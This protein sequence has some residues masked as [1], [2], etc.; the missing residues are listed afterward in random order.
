MTRFRRCFALVCLILCLCALPA[1]A[2]PW[3]YPP[4][5]R[6]QEARDALRDQAADTLVPPP[7]SLFAEEPS[8]AA[9]YAAGTLD[10]GLIEA[11]LSRVNFIRALAGLNPVQ[12]DDGLNDI[13]Q[14]GAVLMA[15]LETITHT[16]EKP[17]DMDEAFFDKGA[18]AAANGNLAFFN[19]LTPSLAWESIDLFAL[20]DTAF[21]LAYLGHRRWLL[22][23]NMG[24]AG[25]G[26]ASDK[27]GC[28]YAVLYVTDTSAPA[29]YDLI[30]WPSEGA[31]P[32]EL[33]R[34]ETPWSISLNTAKYD[35]DKSEPRVTLEER[36]S[37][38]LWTFDA[39][40]SEPKGGAYF[41]IETSGYG[42]GPALIFRPDL[43]DAPALED[44][45]EQN[46][47]W[48]VTLSGLA[49]GDGAPAEDVAYMVDMVSLT[50]ID[51]ASVEIEP[52]TLE[53]TVGERLTVSA[54][55]YPLWAD[56]LSYTLSTS[57]EAVAVVE[58]G[59]IVAKAEGE[60]VLRAETVNGR[61]D[62]VPV[63]VQK[64]E[65]QIQR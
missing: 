34:A 40:D 43:A 56:D 59:S 12:A 21:N 14:H 63:A 16:P 29:D 36:S 42:D 49:S 39:P 10:E 19:W 32:A 24:R 50:P 61:W 3:T 62:E 54:T 17:E 22:S 60:C 41:L 44:G 58:N 23:P 45:Y 20:D 35:L 4:L 64:R 27:A 37:G 55:V 15:S 53:M 31:F 57:D 30:R 13:A 65:Q 8:P 2:E 25:F 46:Q 26:L 1:R 5:N 28:C 51:P 38:A 48:R 7:D 18:Q 33:M 52:R 9:P 6:L 47:V 11:A